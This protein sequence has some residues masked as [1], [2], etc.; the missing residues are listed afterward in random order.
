[1]TYWLSVL[2]FSRKGGKINHKARK[3][4]KSKV[5]KGSKLLASANYTKNFML[6]AIKSYFLNFLIND[7]TS[8]APN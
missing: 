1:M 6:F 4:K 2:A 3:V 8:G 7:S 5:R